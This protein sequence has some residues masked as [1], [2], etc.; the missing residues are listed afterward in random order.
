MK[1]LKKIL[2]KI[3]LVDIIIIAVILVLGSVFFLFFY[4]KAEYIQI[5]VKVTDQDI[6]YAGTAPQTWYADR[7][8]IGDGERD[9]LGRNISEITGIEKFNI[10][11][12]NKAIYLD[13]KVRAVYDT[14]TK[15]YST[16]GKN[17]A[18]GTAL[19]FNLSKVTFNALVTEFPGSETQ[20]NFKIGTAIISS[21]A[22]SIEP[23]IAVS[24]KKGDK[25]L[26]SN[27]NVLAEI[28]DIQVKP[29]EQVTQTDNGE[30]LLRY[31]PLYKDILITARVR[32]KSLYNETF[33][34]DNL[35]LKIGEP[36]PLNFEKV[37][38]YPFIVEF[39]VT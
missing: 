24:L 16:R 39:K 7:F 28:L 14:R 3:S 23:A 22:R 11:P 20:Q 15:L 31:N 27:N 1:F 33:I 21:I 29:A 10:G 35:P 9:A 38:V 2:Q 32:T 37:T 19:K 34:F 6:L 17:L 5:R 36:Q 30:L 4:R 18:F 13:L 25:I 8:E 12:N 26:D